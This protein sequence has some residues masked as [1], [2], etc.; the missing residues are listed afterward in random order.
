[1]QRE[2]LEPGSRIADRFVVEHRAGAGGMGTVYRA[3]DAHTGETVAL[4]LLDS[5]TV[6][7]ERMA[8]EASVLASLDH[9]AIVRYVAHGTSASGQRFLAMEWIDG[10]D[11]ESLLARR[12]LTTTEAVTLGQRIAAAL[13]AAHARGVV[14]R[15]I[16]PSNVMLPHGKLDE[17]KLV[18]FGIARVPR[19]TVALTRPGTMLGTPGYM[20]PEQARGEAK[21]DGRVDVFAFG[22]VLFEALAGRPAFVGENVLAVLAKVL[23]DE[24]PMLRAFCPSA[25]SALEQL[26]AMMMAREASQRLADGAAVLDAFEKLSRGDLLTEAQTTRAAVGAGEL[27]L[28]SVVLASRGPLGPVSLADTL[29]TSST[30]ELRAVAAAAERYRIEPLHLADGSYVLAVGGASIARDQAAMAARC[31]LALQQALPNAAIVVATGRAEVSGRVPIGEVIDRAARLAERDEARRWVLVDATTRHLLDARFSVRAAGAEFVL[32]NVVDAATTARTLL[33][34][35]TRCV[36]RERELGALLGTFDD[37]VNEASARAVLLTGDAGVGKSR[38]VSEF[39]ARLRSRSTPPRVYIARADV[40]RGSAPLAMIADLVRQ[41]AGVFPADSEAANRE[42]LRVLAERFVPSAH[43]QRVA[44]F[45]GEVVGVYFDDATVPELAVSRHNAVVMGT[46]RER[47]VLE[48]LRGEC[49]HAP[50]VLV[51]EDLHWGEQATVRLLHEA[52]RTVNDGSLFVLAVARPEIHALF[53]QLWKG[54][55]VHEVAL[56]GLTKRAA[57]SLAVEVL[58]A[59]IDPARIRSIIEQSG[60]NALFLEELL[61]HVAE[62]GDASLPD[63]LVAMMQLRLEG[64]DS[65]S[66][67]I[68]RAASVFGE[69][70]WLGGV[71]ALL[72][73]VDRASLLA[74]LDALAADEYVSS[75]EQARFAGEREYRFRHALAREAAYAML[76]EADRFEAHRQAAT[77]LASVGESDAVVLAE[78][79]ERGND[80][81]RAAPWFLRAAERAVEQD[82]A[83]LAEAYATRGLQHAQDPV[84]L[85]SLH[86]ARGVARGWQGDWHH[87]VEDCRRGVELLPPDTPQRLFMYGAT[88]MFTSDLGR[89]DESREI[90]AHLLQRPLGGVVSSVDAMGWAM[91]GRTLLFEGEYAEAQRVLA[92]FTKYERED[93]PKDYL[94][95]G[96]GSWVRCLESMIARAD[97][98]GVFQHSRAAASYFER[99]GEHHA[100]LLCRGFEGLALLGLG[101]YSESVALL[102]EASAE[103]IRR[104]NAYAEFNCRGN[105]AFAQAAEGRV[106][107]AV[108]NFTA[109]REGFA[110]GGNYLQEAQLCTALASFYLSS[111]DLDAA[112]SELTRVF[113]LLPRRSPMTAPALATYAQLELRSGNVQRALEAAEELGAGFARYGSMGMNESAMQLARY[114]VLTAVGRTHEAQ[115]LLSQSAN[116]LLERASWIEDLASRASYLERVRKNARLLALAG[117]RG[118]QTS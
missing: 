53:P 20:A 31:A 86:A 46:Q 69:S 91:A 72:A 62:Y 41:A 7:E 21:L 114:D 1:M 70:F 78:H 87:A 10:E 98:W 81:P 64:L 92:L 111:S 34:V 115:E 90:R 84:T 3:R 99:I 95:L 67:R 4:K 80:G 59:S 29:A 83:K 104:G 23:L 105:L 44:A 52:L 27:R 57:E 19:A 97:P 58:G 14:H 37:A 75:V 28:F 9:P 118:A 42:R 94:A 106:L 36:G 82:A 71:L 43:A 60:G 26:L 8:R 47:A 65:D 100:R 17:A 96:W 30:D 50:V 63:T 66:R 55:E 51:L 33:G 32:D 109:A 15:D 48:W 102:E 22:C 79:F 56:S 117:A 73:D 85:G 76:V 112:R 6:F 24:P 88:V 35:E 16:K 68:L 108:A 93:G 5:V 89:F 116:Q 11:L 110:R 13:G 74:R 12:T 77:W 25:S 38:V 2:V 49:E 54:A 18:D 107:D 39:V 40:L 101:R 61:R 45:L 103:S 113:E